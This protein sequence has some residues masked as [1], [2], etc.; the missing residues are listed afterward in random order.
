MKEAHLPISVTSTLPEF[1][2][3]EELCYSHFAFWPS[4]HRSVI[5]YSF[6][7]FETVPERDSSVLFPS[8]AV[9]YLSGI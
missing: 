1:W 7:S 6:A 5:G 2:H 9:S 4:F 8:R 3:C